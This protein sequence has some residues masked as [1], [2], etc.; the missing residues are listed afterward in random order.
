MLILLQQLLGVVTVDQARQGLINSLTGLGFN[1]SSWQ[2]GSFQLTMIEAF[3]RVYANASMGVAEIAA[4]GYND[5]AEKVWLHLFSDSHYD[6]QVHLAVTTQGTCT[7]TAAPLAGPNTFVVDQLVVATPSGI[8]F[9]NKTGGTLVAGG[10]LDLTWE[11]EVAGSAGNVAP[12]TITV[13]QTGIAGVTV[14]NPALT[15]SPTWITRDGADEETDQELRLRN[16]TKWATLGIAPGAA[17]EYFSRAASPSVKRV[18]VDDQNPDG[19][20]TFDIYLAGDSGGV[21]SPVVDAV[22]DYI[23]G[24]TDGID[25]LVTTAKMRV[26]AATNKAIT[27]NA[28]V[29]LLK[30]YDTPAN[31]L[32]IEGAMG[33]YFKDLAIGGTPLYEGGP[34]AVRLNALAGYVMRIPGV[35][36]IAF[37]SPT[38]D[39]DLLK[40]EVAVPTFAPHYYPI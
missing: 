37:T 15:P 40:N 30:A 14:N 8:T 25:R 23:R 10:T 22:E 31:R 21:S 4:G 19:P 33:Q 11:A 26:F 29:Y 35:Q 36:N 38:A 12:G 17:Y 9:R 18:F 1:A 24:T 3:A 32:L 6:N 39:V 2:E 28:G 13:M 20:G 27:I 5:L 16:R 34:G 7:L